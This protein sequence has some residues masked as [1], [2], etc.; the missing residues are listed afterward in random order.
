MRDRG[1][2]RRCSGSASTS[3]RRRW[4]AR[5][6]SPSGRW[7]RSPRRSRIEPEHPDPRRADRAARR[8]ARR[9]QL[10]AAIGAAEGAGRRDPLCLAPLR[11]GARRSATAPRCCA[12]AAMVVTT[13]PR[14][15]DRGAAD[16]RDGRRPGRALRRRRARRR[17]GR[18]SKA[19]GLRLGERACATS[20]FVARRGEVAGADRPARR[21]PERDRTDH[22]RRPRAPTRGTI[23]MRRRGR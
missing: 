8:S 14:R 19:S 10:F 17:R 20:R 6:R 22:R 13:E 16:R 23:A 7:S 3:R 15:L 1:A 5:S 21:R 12:T 2:A 11:R 9:E 18:S 4:S